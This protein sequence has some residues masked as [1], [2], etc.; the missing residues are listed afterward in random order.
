MQNK[1]T[2][3][4]KSHT[5]YCGTR[6]TTQNVYKSMDYNNIQAMGGR[7][8]LYRKTNYIFHIGLM[9]NIVVWG[10]YVKNNI[11]WAGRLEYT[12]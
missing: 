8:K 9:L 11:L 12:C 7:A 6:K 3:R 5:T 10:K 2:Y 1:T 4:I